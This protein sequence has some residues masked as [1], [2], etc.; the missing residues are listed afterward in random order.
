MQKCWAMFGLNSTGTCV[1]SCPYPFFGDPATQLCQLKCPDN[2]FMQLSIATP[3]NRTCV[4]KCEA[5]QWGHPINK[6]CEK[7]PKNCPI[8]F[9]ADN[10]TNKCESRNYFIKIECTVAGEVG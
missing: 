2:Y 7:D 3:I 8:G 5:N 10:H 6:T 1:T 9:F 4:L